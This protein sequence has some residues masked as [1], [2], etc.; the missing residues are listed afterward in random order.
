MN[1]AYFSVVPTVLSKKVL[2]EFG[3]AHP[4]FSPA[5]CKERESPRWLYNE[6]AKDECCDE[7]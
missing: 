1:M 6:S 2:P 5:N 4:D 7:P 3:I